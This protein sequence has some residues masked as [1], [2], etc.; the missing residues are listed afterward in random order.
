MPKREWTVV[1]CDGFDDM[2]T[3]NILFWQA[4]GGSAI[5]QAAWDIVLDYW[6]ANNLDPDELRFCR[7][8]ASVRRT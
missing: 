3:Q 8:T 5:R 4:Q 6:K 1:R 7:S 2:R